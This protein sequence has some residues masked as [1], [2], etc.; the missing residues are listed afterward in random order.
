MPN[1]RADKN[2]LF[3]CERRLLCYC[4]VKVENCFFEFARGVEIGVGGDCFIVCLSYV[5]S[6]FIIYL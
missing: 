4:G 6:I 1:W 5:Y 3:V 2:S